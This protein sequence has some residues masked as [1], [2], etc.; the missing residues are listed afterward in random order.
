M[1]VSNRIIEKA[2]HY[3]SADTSE[4]LERMIL[5]IASHSN[6]NDL[7]SSVDDVL[8]W[9]PLVDELT[10][11]TLLDNIGYGESDTET[12]VYVIN[13]H[14]DRVEYIVNLNDLTNDEFMVEAEEQGRV[15]TLKGFQIAFNESEVNSETDVIRFIE[16]AI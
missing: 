10:C 6:T 9:S 12:R 5:A 2:R 13:S 14:D 16:V 1:K 7:A 11:E 4:E 15:Y 8:V 3:L